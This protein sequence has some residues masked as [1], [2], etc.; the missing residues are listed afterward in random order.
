MHF[1]ELFERVLGIFRVEEMAEIE[2]MVVDGT[3][4]GYNEK[5]KLNWMRGK[6]IREVSS[7]VKVELVVGKM[8]N[9]KEVIFGVEMGR[10]YSDERKLLEGMIGKVKARSKYILGDALYGK[11]VKVLRKLFE[12]AEE[13][14][15][16]IKDTLHTRVRDPIRKKVRRM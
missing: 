7:H 12:K 14:I 5:R 11:S 13:V 10:A 3:G 8:G 4:F 9:G 15:V 2:L 16:P 1:E 6:K